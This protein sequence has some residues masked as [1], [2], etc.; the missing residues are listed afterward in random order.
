MRIVSGDLA[1][2]VGGRWGIWPVDRGADVRFAVPR[3][4][5]RWDSRWISAGDY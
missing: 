3:R 5:W 4:M 2:K 1:A